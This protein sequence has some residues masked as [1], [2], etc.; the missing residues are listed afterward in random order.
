MWLDSSTMV[1]SVQTPDGELIFTP[2]ETDQ[3]KIIW[4]CV[5]GEGATEQSLPPSCVRVEIN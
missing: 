5:N 1:L 4:D 2:A 3:G